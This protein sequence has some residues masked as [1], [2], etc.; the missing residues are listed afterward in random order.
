MASGDE[1]L[2]PRVFISHQWRDKQVADR[3]ARDLEAFA[4]VWMDY[5]NLRPGDLI[6]ETIDRVLEEMDLVLVLW[7]R[8]AEAS[9]GVAA[10]IER[11]LAMGRRV[12]P[13]IFEYGEDGNPSPPLSPP[14]KGILGVDFHH[15]GSGL[16]QVANLVVQLQ[17]DRLPEGGALDDHPARRMLDYLRG[18][19][20]YLANYRNL[21]GVPD[22]RAEWVDRIISEI[23]RF[24]ETGGDRGSV[25]G[26]LESARQSS[27]HDPEGIGMLVS[28]LERLLGQEAHAPLRAPPIPE[29][30]GG[31]EP[32]RWTPPAPPP[33]DELE[34]RVRQ[35][36]PGGEADA[37]VTRVEVYVQSAPGVLSAL[38][39]FA[40]AAGSPAGIRVVEYLQGYLA[41]ADD[42]IPNHMGRYGL[43]DDAWLILNTAFRL[44][45]SGLVP[46]ASLPADWRTI[47]AADHVVRSVIPPE[48]L[49]ALTGIVLQ[50]L[51]VIGDEVAAYRPWFTPQGA[52][53]APVMAA[54]GSSGGTWEDRMNAMLLGTGLSVDG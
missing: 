54:P 30:G 34:L 52:G 38:E 1:G 20:S 12:V 14:L 41:A 42:L 2:R 43:L 37:W 26:L 17:R 23:E 16:A 18:Y 45:E 35:L 27:A 6:Q 44:M 9:E 15:Y 21:Q 49:E 8:H 33:A 24:V 32:F 47:M 4:H 51:Q 5:R 25:R 50:L 28:R 53:Y 13:L 31:G 29:E 10:E 39:S 40:H 11:G 36:V 46:P 48:A 19:L 22:R 7:S 3:L